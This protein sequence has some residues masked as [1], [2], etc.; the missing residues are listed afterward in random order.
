M[1][2][3]KAELIDLDMYSIVKNDPYLLDLER[4]VWTLMRLAMYDYV[5]VEMDQGGL[6][7]MSLDSGKKA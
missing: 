5:F 3:K 1:P 7:K 4:I 6:L 2:R